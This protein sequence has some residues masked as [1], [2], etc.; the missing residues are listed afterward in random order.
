MKASDHPAKFG[1]HIH[2]SSEDIMFLVCHIISQDH[3]VKGS[4]EFMGVSLSF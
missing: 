3:A 1:G 4:F 2:L